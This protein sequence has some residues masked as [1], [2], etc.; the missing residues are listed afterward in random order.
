[1][2]WERF[3]EA[4]AAVWPGAELLAYLN[5]ALDYYHQALD[6]LPV[7]AVDDLAVAHNQLGLIY[8][9]AGDLERALP[10][11][12]ESI[13]YAELQGDFYG[14][15]QTRR[16]VARAL[17]QRGRLADAREYARAALRNF[18][19]YGERAAAEIQKTEGLLAWIEEA[20]G[21]SNG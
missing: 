9:E 12:R 4:R 18:Q 19:V 20:M 17:V 15:G 21:S 3:K 2:A 13:R 5:A 1:M 14:V 16:N 10:H 11:Y 8:Y 6:L 7:D